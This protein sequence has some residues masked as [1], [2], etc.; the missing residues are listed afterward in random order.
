[1]TTISAIDMMVSALAIG[2]T[3]RWLVVRGLRRP[4]CVA[5]LAY[6]YHNSRVLNELKVIQLVVAARF[7]R[8][9]MLN[10]LGAKIRLCR[11]G[12]RPFAK[13]L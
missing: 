2:S 11:A 3:S 4:Q 8:T 13:F 5:G 10:R 12:R 6:C 7:I 9:L 1:M